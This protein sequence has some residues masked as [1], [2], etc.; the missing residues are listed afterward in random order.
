[1]YL[2]QI[3]DAV[4]V[5]HHKFMGGKTMTTRRG[6]KQLLLDLGYVYTGECVVCRGEVS[7]RGKQDS[8][9]CGNGCDN[10][11]VDVLVS[12]PDL[13]ESM[14]NILEVFRIKRQT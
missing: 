12:D 7:V 14:R 1:M 6:N 4:R 2:V 11:V 5:N 3:I 10:F 13:G 9:F 8:P